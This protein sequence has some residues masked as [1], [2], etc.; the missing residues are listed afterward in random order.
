MF[1]KNVCA[2]FLAHTANLSF[3][4]VN[5]QIIYARASQA[6]RPHDCA[7]LSVCQATV[8]HRAKSVTL[9][10]RGRGSKRGNSAHPC[11]PQ[12]ESK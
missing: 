5:E 4:Q 11:E 8:A 10:K 1:A 3:D 6:L 12:L 2:Q 9:I 7:L